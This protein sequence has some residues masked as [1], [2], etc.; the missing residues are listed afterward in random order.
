[1]GRVGDEHAIE[2][3]ALED[4]DQD[5]EQAMPTRHLTECLAAGAALHRGSCLL[6]DLPRLE[7]LLAIERV[8]RGVE[9]LVERAARAQ[10]LLVQLH[11]CAAHLSRQGPARG[12]GH[13][14]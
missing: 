9:E 14:S 11:E 7:E 12:V 1:M 13:G 3:A 2:A 6:K 10:H 8:A 4:R 5:A